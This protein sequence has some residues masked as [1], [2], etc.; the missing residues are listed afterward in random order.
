LLFTN[1]GANP[2]RIGDRLVEL[3]DPKQQSAG[4]HVAPFGHIILI[5]SQAVFALFLLNYFLP[6]QVH[7]RNETKRNEMKSTK[8]KRNEINKNETKR[9]EINEMKTK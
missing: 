1:P 3:L 5:P 6:L 2:R 8:T 7:S 9:N 4:K